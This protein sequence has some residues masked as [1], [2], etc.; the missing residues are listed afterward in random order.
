MPAVPTLP[1]NYV[2]GLWFGFGGSQLQ[3]IGT[4]DSTGEDS[5]VQANCT[6]GVLSGAQADLFGKFAYCNAP[7]FLTAT[8]NL[9]AAGMVSV[10]LNY[11]RVPC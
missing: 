8:Y 1:A 11:C 3:L 9:V 7:Y 4:I 5:L 10:C 2:A 6:Q